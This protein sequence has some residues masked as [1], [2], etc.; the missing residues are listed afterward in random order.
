LVAG[1]LI[2]WNPANHGTGTIEPEYTGQDKMDSKP[3]FPAIEVGKL[4]LPVLE[5]PVRVLFLCTGNSCRSQMAEALL[6]RDGQST[7]EVCSAGMNPTAVNPMAIRVMAEMGV[8]LAGYKSKGVGQYEGDF[9]DYVI[10]LCGDAREI[11]PTFPGT[12]LKLHWA[13]P[14]PARA[15][16]TE[17]E[18][19]KVFRE[20][21]DEIAHK[22]E[23]L[24]SEIL[25]GFLQEL[26]QLWLA[27]KPAGQDIPA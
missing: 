14:D 25:D 16:G 1:A 9:F 10:T 6:R 15:E 24:L 27:R 8:D 11:C 18:R 23:D 26:H 5:G 3:Q 17:E 19:L 7:V 2:L 22:V 4:T 12:P 20:V 21:R 13:L